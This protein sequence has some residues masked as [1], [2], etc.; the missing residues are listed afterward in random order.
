MA[1]AQGERADLRAVIMDEFH[2]Y[3]DR[4]ARHGLAGAVAHDAGARFLLMSATLGAT[5]ISSASSS[6]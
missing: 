1:L 3:S 6:G 4:G 2:Y 5:A